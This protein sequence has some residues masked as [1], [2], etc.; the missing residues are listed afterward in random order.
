M[1]EAG[2]PPF[3]RASPSADINALD[4]EFLYGHSALLY[5]LA[6]RKVH[7]TVASGFLK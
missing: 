7:R 4:V 5:G 2:S 6:N 1:E 3:G